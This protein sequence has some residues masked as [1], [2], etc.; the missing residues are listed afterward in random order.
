MKI[1]ENIHVILD[2]QVIIL[3]N[4]IKK[5]VY[6]GEK[7]KIFPPIKMVVEKQYIC[8]SD[9]G[10]VKMYDDIEDY[11]DQFICNMM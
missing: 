4:Y 1:L 5:T 3:G 7:K 2:V 6:Q 9:K 10:K 11:Q 8:Q